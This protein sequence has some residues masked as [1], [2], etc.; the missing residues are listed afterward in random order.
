MNAAPRL[1]KRLIL[2]LLLAA[3]FSLAQEEDAT[4]QSYSLAFDNLNI[5]Q[6]ATDSLQSSDALDRAAQA[7]RPLSAQ[8]NSTAL[9]AQLETTFERAKQTL[10]NQS[11]ADLGVQVAVLKGGFQRLVYEAA[12]ASAN[13][14][15]LATTQARL[16]RI[17]NDMGLSGEVQ[18]ALSS[19]TNLSKLFATFEVATANVVKA[20]LG[21]VQGWLE[22]DKGVAYQT[23]AT[24][25]S[26][27]LIVQDSPRADASSNDL[28][29]ESFTALVADDTET[30]GQAISQLNTQMDTFASAASAVVS[31][32]VTGEVPT[33]ETPVEV[34]Q[35]EAVTPVE[36]T[37]ETTTEIGTTAQVETT[38]Q[39]ETVAQ[40]E[41][42]TT[43]TS[44]VDA[45]QIPVVAAEPVIVN[46]FVEP[47]GNEL[48]ALGL[49]PNQQTA[50]SEK[51]L[52]NG[53]TSV[54]SVVNE[55]L[56][57]TSLA[58][59]AV[60]EGDQG[61]AK[62][63]LADAQNIYNEYL[64]PVVSD[65]SLNSSVSGL[66]SSLSASPSLRQEDLATLNQQWANL[67]NTLNISAPSS[68]LQGVANGVTGF[69][70]GWPRMIAMIALGLLAFV[71]L[72]LLFLAFGGGN[73]NWQLIGYA[74]FLLLVPVIYEGLSFL[75]SLINS[76]VNVPALEVLSRFSFFQNPV[77]HVVWAVL[78]GI[79]ILLA[80]MGLY[81]ICVQFGLLGRKTD[82]L[83]GT[84]IETSPSA[85]S[86]EKAKTTNFE[87]DEEF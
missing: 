31:G 61:F 37:A 71:P 33:T 22:S 13:A 63:Q 25:Y 87:W 27:F 28:F 60:Q 24:A 29:T 21:N 46:P 20:H 59:S 69:W 66:L 48:A 54:K 81:G 64:S 23:L 77:M 78:T 43:E 67:A 79:A 53:F 84:V 8:S 40:T 73:R 14:G 34:V 35:P 2:G 76:F 12:V 1:I 4:L 80:S 19:E 75:L 85:T 32:A 51:W 45:T 42:P 49:S 57:K 6:H 52:D 38:T 36:A 50:L 17:A 83:S 10:Q 55:L 11:E 3:S 68:G 72:Y 62:G 7:L 26:D 18:N 30:L 44:P 41:T 16:T 39:P 47:L 15:D 86:I 70:S 82:D 56:A 58:M 74:L 9:V 65:S 5:A